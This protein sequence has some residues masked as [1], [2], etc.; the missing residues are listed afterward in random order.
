M[1]VSRG[2]KHSLAD[3]AGHE[4]GQRARGTWE[5]KKKPKCLKEVSTSSWP[6]SRPFPQIIPGRPPKM[7]VKTEIILNTIEHHTGTPDAACSLT[8][9][10]SRR[11]SAQRPGAAQQQVQRRRPHAARHNVFSALRST[12][13]SWM[14]G[15]ASLKA[16]GVLV[17]SLEKLPRPWLLGQAQGP[18]SNRRGP[19]KSSPFFIICFSP[20]PPSIP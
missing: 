11:N 13:T 15:M 18:Q 14:G 1:C 9:L 17:F 16:E 7:A 10:P 3:G 12:Q 5:A 2:S 19:L 4:H 8:L 20:V 6:S